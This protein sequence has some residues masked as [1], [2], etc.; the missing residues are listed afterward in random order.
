MQ[1]YAARN[2]QRPDRRLIGFESEKIAVKSHY[3]PTLGICYLEILIANCVNDVD[4]HTSEKNVHSKTVHAQ[5]RSQSWG[6]VADHD[7]Q[8]HFTESAPAGSARK[9]RQS[10]KCPTEN[11]TRSTHPV[12]HDFKKLVRLFQT[13]FKR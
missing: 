1:L 11:T 12:Q 3:W 10:M 9:L 5:F 13:I 6:A 8:S 7:E 2:I 4:F